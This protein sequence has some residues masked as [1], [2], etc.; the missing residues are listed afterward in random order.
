MKHY[1]VGF[2]FKQT[3]RHL[4]QTFYGTTVYL[5]VGTIRNRV[6]RSITANVTR[7][8][9]GAA[10]TGHSQPFVVGVAYGP[11]SHGRQPIE[12]TFGRFRLKKLPLLY[13]TVTKSTKNYDGILFSFQEIEFFEHRGV[14]IGTDVRFIIVRGRGTSPFPDGRQFA[15]ARINRRR[16]FSA[17]FVT[18]LGENNLKNKKKF[19]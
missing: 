6:L 11:R 19:A 9:N 16:R 7:N 5:I 1:I 17:D 18:G 8:A 15:A 13:T 3:H 4:L 2:C 12:A 14:S 10:Q